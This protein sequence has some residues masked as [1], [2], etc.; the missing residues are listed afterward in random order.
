M[1]WRSGQGSTALHYA[2][3][4]SR[5][6]EIRALLGLGADPKIADRFGRTPIQMTDNDD[7]RLLLN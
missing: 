3:K 7:V 6:K 4:E 2:V 5:C 1:N